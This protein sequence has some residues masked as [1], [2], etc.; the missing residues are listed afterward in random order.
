V[1]RLPSFLETTEML[2]QRSSVMVDVA[3]SCMIMIHV[4]VELQGGQRPTFRKNYLNN[5]NTLWQQDRPGILCGNLCTV[6]FGL[7]PLTAI[8]RCSI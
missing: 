4:A 3:H 8:M 1:D 5:Q 6:S 2:F 7:T